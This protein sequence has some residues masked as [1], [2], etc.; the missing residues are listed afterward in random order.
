MSGIFEDELRETGPIP[1]NPSPLNPRRT[2]PDSRLDVNLS[3]LRGMAPRQRS[4]LASNKF[5]RASTATTFV[6]RT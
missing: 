1:L 3:A 4:K 5:G 2:R 6:N